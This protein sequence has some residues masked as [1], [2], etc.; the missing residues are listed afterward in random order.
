MSGRATVGPAGGLFYAVS[1][2]TGPD[3]HV[4]FQTFT[5]VSPAA[6]VI[7][8]FD[9][10]VNDYDQ[11]PIVNPAGLD[12]FASPNQH[13]RVDIL[14]AGTDPFDTGAGVLANFYLGVDP[15]S[16]PNPYTSY[17]FDITALVGGGGDFIL[18]FAQV[19]NQFFLNMGVDNVNVDF[20]AVPEPTTLFLLGTGLLGVVGFRTKFRL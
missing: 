18:R 2:Q 7:L 1:D 16:N 15:G 3:A 8:T 17:L 9:M 20:T 6:S 11:G 10:F 5:V 19:E 14:S 4:L 12:V 13:A